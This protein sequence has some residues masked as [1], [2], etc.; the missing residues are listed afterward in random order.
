MCAISKIVIKILAICLFN[1]LLRAETH[2]G[3]EGNRLEQNAQARL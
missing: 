1:Q 3:P 2:L